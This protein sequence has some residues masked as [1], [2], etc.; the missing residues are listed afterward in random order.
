M[1]VTINESP[2]GS[3]IGRFRVDMDVALVFFIKSVAEFGAVNGWSKRRRDEGRWWRIGMIRFPHLVGSVG[4]ADGTSLRS[5][6]NVL[7]R[8]EARG[9]KHEHEAQGTKH[10]LSAGVT[11]HEDKKG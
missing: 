5:R 1:F 10:S 6:P 7:T 8:V 11:A 9:G 3:W 2:E 4:K